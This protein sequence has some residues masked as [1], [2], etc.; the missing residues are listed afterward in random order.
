LLN[1]DLNLHTTPEHTI[2]AFCKKEKMNIVIPWKEDTIVLAMA[3]LIPRQARAT[4]P[5]DALRSPV[6]HSLGFG[7]KAFFFFG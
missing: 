3:R 4:T 5:G 2:N 1:P 7:I 6:V